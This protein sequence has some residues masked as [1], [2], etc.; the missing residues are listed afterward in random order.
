[1]DRGETVETDP[2]E[3]EIAVRGRVADTGDQGAMG[4]V[5][6]GVPVDH[7]A[8]EDTATIADETIVTDLIIDL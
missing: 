3:V 6:A 1:M 8:Q 7:G 5:E 2:T 4:T